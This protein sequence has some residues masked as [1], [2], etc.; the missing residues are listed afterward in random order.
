MRHE[1][2]VLPLYI[3]DIRV[4]AALPRRRIADGTFQIAAPGEL[5]QH[6]AALS[7]VRGAQPAVVG[8]A[9]LRLFAVHR[10]VDGGA[11]AVPHEI[12]LYAPLPYKRGKS[13]VL[14]AGLIEI[15]TVLAHRFLGLQHP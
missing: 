7:K 3:L 12:L 4:I 1:K 13:P 11:F 14:R 8:A 10:R 9:P 2:V 6:T 15:Y 5:Q